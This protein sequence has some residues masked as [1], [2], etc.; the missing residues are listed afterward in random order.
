MKNF[1]DIATLCFLGLLTLGGCAKQQREMDTLQPSQILIS[2]VQAGAGGNNNHEFIEL[3]NYGGELVDLQGWSLVYRLPASEDDLPVL[4]WEESAFIPPFGYF[5]L[6]RRGQDFGVIPD[7]FF[8]QAMN[9]SGGGLGLLNP[10]GQLVDALA[11]GNAPDRFTEGTAAPA[12]VD[13]QSLMR[14]KGDAPGEMLDLDV[15]VS[16]FSFNPE[17]EPRNVIHV[18]ASTHQHLLKLEVSS[19]EEV[20]PG[21]AFNYTITATNQ[22]EARDRICNREYSHPSIARRSAT[23]AWMEKR[24]CVRLVAH[25][26]AGARRDSY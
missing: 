15:N 22:G 11:W 24:G 25:R 3:Y 18:E 4:T 10:D 26:S 21:S 14:R 5:L 8:D 7:A 9:N 23:F 1:R 17:P 20:Q 12:M 19:S 13:D 6:V 16:D 2:Q